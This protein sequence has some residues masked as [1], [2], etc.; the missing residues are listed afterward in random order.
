MT[1][2]VMRGGKLVDKRAA[3]LNDQINAA[4]RSL[5]DDM[6]P[7]FPMPM[8]SRMQ[9]FESPVT[10]QEITTWRE[11]DADMKAVDA[12]D[13]RDLAPGH[14][15]ARGREKQGEETKNGTGRNTD[16]AAFKWGGVPSD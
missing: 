6:W 10:G 8:V 7:P 13:P 5:R 16:D 11:R 12:F 9:P 2:Y 14:R 15:Y 1:V 4:S 3:R